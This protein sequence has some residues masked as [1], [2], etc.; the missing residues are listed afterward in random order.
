MPDESR[1]NGEA[2]AP[3]FS[4]VIPTR[5]RATL[6]VRAIDSALL[7]DFSD[8]EIVIVDNGSTDGTEEVIANYNDPRIRYFW[9]T[10]AGASAGTR[11]AS[12]SSAA[13]GSAAGAAPSSTPS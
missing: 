13:A 6:I 5:N 9:Q 8:F 1:S 7:Q 3:F 4:I 11:A 10:N 12:R 2:G